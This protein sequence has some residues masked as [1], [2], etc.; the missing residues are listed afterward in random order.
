MSQPGLY[1]DYNHPQKFRGRQRVVL[2]GVPQQAGVAMHELS[3]AGAPGTSR[4]V[5]TSFVESSL[6]WA[7][8]EANAIVKR[9]AASGVATNSKQYADAVALANKARKEWADHVMGR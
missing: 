4:P 7:L 6:R 1:L 5:A 8:D 2:P 9:L 3:L